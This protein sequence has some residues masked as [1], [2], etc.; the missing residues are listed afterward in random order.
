MAANSRDPYSQRHVQTEITQGILKWFGLGARHQ[1]NFWR[2]AFYFGLKCL[3]HQCS[4]FL[5]NQSLPTHSWKNH[6]LLAFQESQRPLL[7]IAARSAQSPLPQPILLHFCANLEDQLFEKWGVRIPPFPPLGTPLH[8][9]NTLRCG[10][11]TLFCV[12]CFFVKHQATSC[13]LRTR[14]TNLIFP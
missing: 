6:S 1:E 5:R 3:F 8:F 11:Q 12:G 4:A 2:Y 10:P 9:I 14:Q 13:F 7:D